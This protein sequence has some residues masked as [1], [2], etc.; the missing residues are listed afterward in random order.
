[1]KND[2]GFAS[3]RIFYAALARDWTTAQEIL[4][5]SSNEDLSF[6]RETIVPRGCVEIWL[7]RVRG[8]HPITEAGFYALRDQLDRK[9]KADPQKS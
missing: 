3:Q 7:A 8:A 1:M 4:S 5:N 9:V 6:F 2:I